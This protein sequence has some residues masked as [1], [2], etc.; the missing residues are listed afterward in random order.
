MD[1]RKSFGQATSGQSTA[2]ALGTAVATAKDKVSDVASDAKEQLAE[3]G[4][5]ATE[6]FQGA[7][8]YL[9][10]TDFIEMVEDVTGIVKRYPGASLAAAVAVGYLLANAIHRRD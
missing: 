10:N 2:A 9:R 3:V 8:D 5:K 4:R 6:K 1:D 7:T